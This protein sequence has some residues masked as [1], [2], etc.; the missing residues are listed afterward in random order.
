MPPLRGVDRS[1][2]L[3]ERKESCRTAK[4]CCRILR[5]NSAVF[6]SLDYEEVK[7]VWPAALVIF[8][9]N[10]VF[11]GKNFFVSLCVSRLCLSSTVQVLLSCPLVPPASR[12]PPPVLLLALPSHPPPLRVHEEERGLQLQVGF[13]QSSSSASAV[14]RQLLKG[15]FF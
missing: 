11:T 4:V 14:S 10:R 13:P 1:S 2:T 7:Q 9:I 6:A 8:V 12:R 5:V 3:P 15:F